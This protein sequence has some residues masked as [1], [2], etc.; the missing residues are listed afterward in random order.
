[1]FLIAG[2]SIDVRGEINAA[3][4]GGEGSDEGSFGG[5]GGGAGGMIGFDAPTIT[6]NNLLLANGG[7]GGGGSEG[8]DS[9]S[10]GDDS[11]AI[12]AAHGGRGF[13]MGNGGDGS[14]AALAGPGV[15]GSQGSTF[16]LAG[17]GGGGGGAGL[18]KAPAT[19]NLGTLLL[20]PPAT[21]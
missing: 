10:P 14:P 13:G 20:S 3:G 12:T 1:M 19:A 5:S 9:G 8:L 7:G 15:T 18:I 11:D 6:C 21:P 4:E 17:G 2:E 16:N